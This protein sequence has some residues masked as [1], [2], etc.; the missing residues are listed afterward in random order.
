MAERTNF[1][2]GTKFE[3]IVGYSRA[4]RAGNLIFISGTTAVDENGGIHGKSDVYE[5]AKFIFSKIEK[6]LIQAGASL[7]DVVR[8]RIFVTDINRWEEAGRAHAEF[9]GS[10]KPCCTMVEIKSLVDK[11]MLVEIETEAVIG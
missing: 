4:V 10:I 1:S 7:K 3:S 5:Q 9:F 8:N 2:S 6:V 11:D